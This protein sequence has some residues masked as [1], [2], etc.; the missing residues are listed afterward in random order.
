VYTFVSCDKLLFKFTLKFKSHF[1]KNP[2]ISFEWATRPCGTVHFDNIFTFTLEIFRDPILVTGQVCV[3]S[4]K[5]PA[6][7]LGIR[8][9]PQS[10]R[11]NAR[12]VPSDMPIFF[13][14][15]LTHSPL[16]TMFPHF[17]PMQMKKRGY[18]TNNLPIIRACLNYYLIKLN[19]TFNFPFLLRFKTTVLWITGMAFQ[20]Q[21]TTLQGLCSRGS[22]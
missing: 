6:G 20:L 4:L 13:L 17:R 5:I 8:G 9:F 19:S 15:I 1:V 21:L 18:I 12:I 10:F 2:P 7:N 14:R 11:V 16:L 22:S 3:K